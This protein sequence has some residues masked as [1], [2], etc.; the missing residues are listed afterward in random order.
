MGL[1][2]LAGNDEGP[3]T[4]ERS[5][6]AAISLV[7]H[8]SARQGKVARQDHV[9]DP[10]GAQIQHQMGAEAISR[11]PWR[12]QNIKWKQKLNVSQSTNI[13]SILINRFIVNCVFFSRRSLLVVTN[14]SQMLIKKNN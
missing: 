13:L 9:R 11:W 4:V 3:R 2:A 14:H 10:P 8:G 1:L 7:S 12:K 5:Q 6:G